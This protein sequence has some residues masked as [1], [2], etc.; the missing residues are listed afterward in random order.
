ML[1]DRP[2]DRRDVAAHR[3]RVLDVVVGQNVG[4]RDAEHHRRADP[5]RG[6][7]ILELAGRRTSSSTR[8]CR[9]ASDT[10]RP[11]RQNPTRR[12]ECRG[13]CR[14]RR[15]RSRRPDRPSPA[16]PCPQPR[17]PCATRVHAPAV[18]IGHDARD[19]AQRRPQRRRSAAAE[20]RSLRGDVLIEV[21]DGV[22]RQTQRIVF[23]VF[24]R[25]E[26]SPLF[27][28]PRREDD[29]A[30]RPPAALHLLGDRRAPLRECSRCRSRCRRRPVPSRRDG[31]R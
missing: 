15:S 7:V 14:S 1:A 28:V 13:G 21:R 25:A 23:D 22:L 2:V 31:R 17:S 10:R 27:G 20:S 11:R 18:R 12:S 26:Q 24:R 16:R 3:A 29:R 30:L 4:V 8:S 19:V 9:T 5:R 6:G